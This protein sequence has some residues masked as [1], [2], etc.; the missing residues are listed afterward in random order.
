[1]HVKRGEITSHPSFTSLLYSVVI[2]IHFTSKIT[3]KSAINEYSVVEHVSKIHFLVFD[4]SRI[5]IPVGIL[6]FPIAKSQT[7]QDPGNLVLA[8]NVG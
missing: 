4:E 2:Y 6:K 5:G 3:T 8:Q 1:M 7:C